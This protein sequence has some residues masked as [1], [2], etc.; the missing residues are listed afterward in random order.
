MGESDS[1][2]LISSNRDQLEFEHLKYQQFHRGIKVQ[3]GEYTV[4]IK[5]QQ[6]VSVSGSFIAIETPAFEVKL[7]NEQALRSALEFVG[8][9]AYVW[10]LADGTSLESGDRQQ[11]ETDSSHP[12]NG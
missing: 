9:N 11:E 6:I 3:G 8:A 2:R 10:E 1:M 4:H 5:D 7:S 12:P